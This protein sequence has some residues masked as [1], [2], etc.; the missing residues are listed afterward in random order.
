MDKGSILVWTCEA[1]GKPDVTYTW[2]RNAQEL[3]SGM[4]DESE[5]GRYRIYE[6]VLTID[7]VVEKDQAMYQCKATNQVGSV[8]SAGQLRVISKLFLFINVMFFTT[9]FFLLYI[10]F[11]LQL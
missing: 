4:L 5:R 9:C 10:L 6:N 3:Y 1:F 8:Y 2:L 11:S 7:G